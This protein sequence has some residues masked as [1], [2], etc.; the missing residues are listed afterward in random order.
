MRLKLD[1]IVNRIFQEITMT[2]RPL[3]LA[4]ILSL[5]PTLL[6]GMETSQYALPLVITSQVPDI[7]LSTYKAKL[8]DMFLESACQKP[9]C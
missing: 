8:A 2:F 4:L 6:G 3:S 7:Y 1:L 5:I 9:G